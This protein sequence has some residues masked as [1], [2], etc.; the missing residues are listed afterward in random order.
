MSIEIQIVN[1]TVDI[2]GGVT[3]VSFKAIKASND[4]FY[5]TYGDCSFTASYKSESFIPLSSLKNSDGELEVAAG[6]KINVAS[7]NKGL[8]ADGNHGRLAAALAGFH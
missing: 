5:K 6:D 8:T 1:K 4:G 7:G 3:A 2:K